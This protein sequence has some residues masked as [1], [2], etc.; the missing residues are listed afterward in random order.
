MWHLKNH[1]GNQQ[2]HSLQCLERS[3]KIWDFQSHCPLVNSVIIL[4][5][6]MDETNHQH[7]HS[8]E[9]KGMVLKKYNNFKYVSITRLLGNNNNKKCTN[10]PHRWNKLWKIKSTSAFVKA[11]QWWI[12]LWTKPEI[13]RLW[14]Q[15]K[16]RLLIF[17]Q[18]LRLKIRFT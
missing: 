12:K 14:C 15:E 5:I 3:N 8:L 6:C 2:A 11:H 4:T 18:R 13:I 16:L 7:G 10:L 1:Q 9:S 17:L